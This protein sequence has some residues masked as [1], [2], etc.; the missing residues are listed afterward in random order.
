MCGRLVQSPASLDP[1][2][3]GAGGIEA[4][5]AFRFAKEPIPGKD[6]FTRE[7]ITAAIEGIFPTIEVVTSRWTP[8]LRSSRNA[9]IAD[10]LSNGALVVGAVIRNWRNIALDT[11]QV[12]LSIN[13]TIVHRSSGG[14][15][16]KDLVS[17]LLMFANHLAQ[18]GLS[19][20]PGQIVTTGSYTG[21][22]TAGPGNIISAKFNQVGAVS[23]QFQAN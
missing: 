9:M 18:R 19:I 17:L 8:A 16:Q 1:A 20:K 23:V 3:Y 2:T 13:D 12:E 21:F 5:I 4:E 15:P 11:L 10:L 22:L 14:N 6:G 7:G